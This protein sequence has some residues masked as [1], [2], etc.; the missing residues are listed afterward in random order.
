MYLILI[1][2]LIL[3]AIGGLPYISGHGFGYAP[4]GVGLLIV[5]ILIIRLVRG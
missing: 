3:L 1:I 5:V 4:S 2:I